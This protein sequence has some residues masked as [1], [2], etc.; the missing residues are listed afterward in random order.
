MHKTKKYHRITWTARLQI[1]ALFNAGH[2]YRF[3]ALQVGYTA[4]AIHNEVKHGLYNH[5]N[6]DTW[7]YEKRYSAQI[8]QEYTDMQ[9]TSKGCDIKLGHNYAYANYVATQV[10]QGVSPDIIVGT[11]KRAGKWT[12]ST[13]TLYRYIDKGYIM[14]VTNGDL[15]EKPRRKRRYRKVKKASKRPAGTSIERRP[16][17]VQQRKEFGHWELDSVIGKIKGK[18]QSLL[19]LTERVTRFEIIV[20]AK[21][22]T[23]RTTVKMLDNIFKQYPQGTFKTITVDN[24]AE[25]ADAW[26]M[27]HDKQGNKRTSVYYCHPFCSAERGSNERQ[28]RIIRRYFP[29][30]ANFAKITA[31][32]CR[33]V[34]DKIN[35]MPRKILGYQSAAECFKDYIKVT[36]AMSC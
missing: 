11:L 5:L 3:I 28:N 31:K 34:Q 6:G 29:K 14:G 13:T 21:D 18:R 1:E 23:S 2:T 10:K 12:V 27:E 8:A 25:F 15:L 35:N 17:E 19:V 26:G 33:H 20:H 9:A 22:K 32:E 4:A 7:V 36:K 30:G 16:P 24:G